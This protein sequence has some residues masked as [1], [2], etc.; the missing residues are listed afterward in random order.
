MA[1]KFSDN[2]T[3]T[4]HVSNL[5]NGIVAESEGLVLFFTTGLLQIFN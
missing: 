4:E 1:Q 5:V 3:T 2:R